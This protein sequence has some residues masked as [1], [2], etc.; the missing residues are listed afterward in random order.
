MIK[1][2]NVRY[3]KFSE[4]PTCRF[5]GLLLMFGVSLMGGVWLE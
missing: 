5:Q 3:P 1:D 4:T 2:P